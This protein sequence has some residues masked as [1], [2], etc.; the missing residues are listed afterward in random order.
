MGVRDI[1]IAG[2]FSS[3]GPGKFPKPRFLGSSDLCGLFG[4]SLKAY[5]E[6]LVDSRNST[7]LSQVLLPKRQVI[8]SRTSRP[9]FWDVVKEFDLSYNDR[10]TC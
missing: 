3:S 4:P 6:I 2:S 10:D 7:R 9:C 5:L 8:V 1:L